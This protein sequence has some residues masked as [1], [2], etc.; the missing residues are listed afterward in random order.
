MT[1]TASI[2]KLNSFLLIWL[3]KILFANEVAWEKEIIE[4]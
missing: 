2:Q 4:K 3:I 1:I